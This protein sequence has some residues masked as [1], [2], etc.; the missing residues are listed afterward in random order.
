[1][2]EKIWKT[3][4]TDQRHQNT[5]LKYAGTKENGPTCG[6]TGRPSKPR[7]P[8]TNASFNMPNIYKDGSNIV[9]HHT[10]HLSR[11]W[12]QVSFIF[13][14]ACCL[15]L[16][17]YSCIYI[18]QGSV[19][20]QLWCGGI[21]NNT[22]LPIVRWVCKWRIFEKTSIFVKDMDNYKVGRFFETQWIPCFKISG[23]L[24]ISL[25]KI[26]NTWQ[27]CTKFETVMETIIPN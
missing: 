18:S 13:Q 2:T 24:Q 17:V 19:V 1:M 15:L 11:F 6:W 7:R 25:R 20:M 4:S 22:L 26:V 23:P 27:I 8:E 3:G 5:R 12:C 14:H 21:F 9:Y 10:D 16:L